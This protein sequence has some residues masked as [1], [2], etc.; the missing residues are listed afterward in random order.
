MN[1]QWIG[2]FTGVAFAACASL[3][4]AVQPPAQGQDKA[5]S[6]KWEFK[7]V[8]FGGDEKDGTKKLNDLAADGWEYVGPLAQGLVAFKRQAGAASAAPALA[9]D[10]WI[11]SFKG[12][13][14]KTVDQKA[15]A[16]KIYH[17][18][19]QL[20]LRNEL[21]DVVDG[22]LV[23]EEGVWKVEYGSDFKGVIAKDGKRIDWSN[24]TTWTRP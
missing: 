4:L 21:G 2:V 14:P 5:G 12:E 11:C 20:K 19:K 10:T 1:R 23:W 15:R 18:G 17:E 6:P 9:G 13:N 3:F 24:D 16:C 7:A 8:A 22:K